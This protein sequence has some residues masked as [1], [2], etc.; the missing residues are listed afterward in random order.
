M[1]FN[2][3]PICNFCRDKN[4]GVKPDENSTSDDH[5]CICTCHSY[6]EDDELNGTPN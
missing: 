6:W 3:G 1:R 2:E 4:H 5:D